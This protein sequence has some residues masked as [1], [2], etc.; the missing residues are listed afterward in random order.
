MIGSIG[1]IGC[2][3]TFINRTSPSKDCNEDM[4]QK[5]KPFSNKLPWKL[6]E[7]KTQLSGSLFTILDSLKMFKKIR[8][9]PE[10]FGE[11]IIKFFKRIFFFVKWFIFIFIVYY[12]TFHF[13]FSGFTN[14]WDSCV[15]EDAKP[16]ENRKQY[17]FYDFGHN[18][19]ATNEICANNCF[20]GRDACFP[21]NI[22]Q[23]VRAH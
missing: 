10:Q 8:N 20:S 4:N 14:I 17:L 16:C 18:T 21:L 13:K 12:L 23:L 15:G 5:V 19:E 1:P 6:Q 2:A 22:E 9:S 11:L 3:P 7:L